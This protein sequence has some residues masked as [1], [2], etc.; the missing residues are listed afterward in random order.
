MITIKDIAK[1][2]G[3]SYSTV[4]R[5]LN[6][7]PTVSIKTK[8]RVLDEAK[9]LNFLPNANARNLVKK[10]SER[11]GIIFSNNYTDE[12]YRWFFGEI[13]K[14]SVRATEEKSFD[15]IIQ[16]N[17]DTHGNSNLLKIVK[18]QLVDGVLIA[19]KYIKKEEI[20]FLEQYNIPYIILY[21]KPEFNIT[22]NNHYICDDNCY[23]GYIATKHLIDKGHKDIV[24]ITTSAS[25]MKLYHERTKGYCQAM[26]EHQ[27][28]PTILYKNEMEYFNNN[29]FLSDNIEII[30]RASALFIQQDLPALSMIKHL[31]KDYDLQVPN[32]ISVIG[33]ND[34]KMIQ[35][36]DIPLTTVYD[37]RDIVI[38]YA[39][40]ELVNMIKKISILPM[41]PLPKP[42]IIE[43]KTV[44]NLKTT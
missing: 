41:H 6:D 40:N 10:S 1:N 7:D 26:N 23:G 27:L 4:S 44:K 36:L 14:F 13:E 25:D 43:R 15:Y 29:S 22:N 24:T 35:Y 17:Y 19:S 33:Y 31:T 21:F 18:T 39:V 9:R 30:K 32:D 16:A 11:I 34:I 3:V 38:K 28:T 5:C 20:D 42:T 2:L 37:R 8:K 12:M